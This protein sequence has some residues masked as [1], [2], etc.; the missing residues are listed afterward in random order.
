MSYTRHPKNYDGPELTSRPLGALLEGA[1]ER[2][3]KRRARDP[4]AVQALWPMIVGP[5]IAPFTRADRFVDGVLF[6]T[7][8]NSTVYSLLATTEKSILLKQ[9][10]RELP[11]SGVRNIVFRLG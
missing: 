8:S 11:G 1:L 6:V 4:Q 2:I 10:Q 3:E 7:V 5:Q 9:M